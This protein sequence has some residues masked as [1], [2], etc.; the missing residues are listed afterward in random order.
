MIWNVQSSGQ[1]N[2]TEEIEPNTFVQID[3]I[4][5]GL[6]EGTAVGAMGGTLWMAGR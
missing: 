1:E 2:E 5:T 3:L 4:L 6:M